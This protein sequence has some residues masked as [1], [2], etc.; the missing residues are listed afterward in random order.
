MDQRFGLRFVAS[1]IVMRDVAA[2]LP[3]ARNARTHSPE[4]IEQLATII[5]TRLCI[6]PVV[7]SWRRPASTIG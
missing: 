4:Q 6:Q 3:D 7:Q 1:E 2:L 5:R